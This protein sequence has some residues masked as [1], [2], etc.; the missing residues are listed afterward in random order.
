[1][2]CSRLVLPDPVAPTMTV[3]V[4]GRSVTLSSSRC[5]SAPKSK[6]ASVSTTGASQTPGT[7]RTAANPRVSI[8]AASAR[9]RSMVCSKMGTSSDAI[10]R[11]LRRARATRTRRTDSSRAGKVAQAI[12]SEREIARSGPRPAPRA[13]NAC[14]LTTALSRP[15]N[16]I[17]AAT[18]SALSAALPSP[19]RVI[20]PSS[21]MWLNGPSSRSRGRSSSSEPA[22]APAPPKTT[23]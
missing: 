11:S 17:T 16:T 6:P 20:G 18:G 8:D 19:T 13:N 12:T 4:P 23:R 9:A 7:T 2:L 10:D 3:R 5:Q 21:V 22:P 14:T 15:K 1:M